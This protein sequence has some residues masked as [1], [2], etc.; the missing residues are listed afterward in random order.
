MPRPAADQPQLDFSGVLFLSFFHQEPLVD[1]LCDRAL[2]GG[3][4]GDGALPPDDER[5]DV[6]KPTGPIGLLGLACGLGCARRRL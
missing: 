5:L 6:H 2:G 4:P 3:P 1:E